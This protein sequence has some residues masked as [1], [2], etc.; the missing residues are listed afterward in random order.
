MAKVELAEKEVCHKCPSESFCKLTTG[1]SRTIDALNE[2]GAK[3]GDTV[4]IEISSKNI[5]VSAFFVYIYPI[6]VLL[7]AG[8]LTQLISGSQNLAIIIGLTA[9]AVSFL[10]VRFVNRK[11]SRAKKLIPVI[12]EIKN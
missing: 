8:A 10:V 7:F 11:M 6:L 1:G 3:V 5:L 9:L 2:M 4:K 12:K